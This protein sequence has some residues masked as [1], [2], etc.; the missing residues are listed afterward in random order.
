MLDVTHRVITEVTDEAAIET[1][2]AGQFR[3]AVTLAEFRDPRDR[4]VRLVF[5]HHLAGG[6]HAQGLAGDAQYGVAGQADEG[7][8]APLL[9][10]LNGLEEVAAGSATELEVDAQR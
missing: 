8:T 3:H 1:R 2:Q 7:I 6:F 5:F 9:A 10:A 4:V